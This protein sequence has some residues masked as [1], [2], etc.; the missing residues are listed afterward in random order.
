[1]LY[2]GE[3]IR[4]DQD[5]AREWSAIR[6]LWASLLCLC[7]ATS[8]LRCQVRTCFFPTCP[9]DILLRSLCEQGVTQK[10]PRL[11]TLL[12]VRQWLIALIWRKIYAVLLYCPITSP[13]CT[14]PMC[15][16]M[17]WH[18]SRHG[19]SVR[20]GTSLNLNLRSR[21]I[22]LWNCQPSANWWWSKLSARKGWRPNQTVDA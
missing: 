1:M 15:F 19:S 4:A 3:R 20:V 12:F 14:I 10:S 5:Q 21:F 11:A 16:L 17:L 9:S 7:K 18:R 13:F 6:A 22:V 8:L 2:S